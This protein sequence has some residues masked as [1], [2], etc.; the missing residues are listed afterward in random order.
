MAA[1][2]SHAQNSPVHPHRV[3]I[4]FIAIPLPGKYPSPFMTE[5]N[6]RRWAARTGV[7]GCGRC[8]TA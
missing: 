3:Y 7:G 5:L 6:F 1:L 2:C 4:T 8:A